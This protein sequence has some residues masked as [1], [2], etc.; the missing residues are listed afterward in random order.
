MS[1]Y[2][3]HPE[4]FTDLDEIREYIAED[5]PDAADRMIIEIFESIRALVPFPHQGYRRPSLTS[6]PLRFKLVREYVIVYAP[7]KQP[8]WV[9]AIFHGRRSPRVNGRDSQSE[10]VT[11]NTATAL[12]NITPYAAWSTVP[13]LGPCMRERSTRP[14]TRRL[15]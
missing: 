2:A 7:E 13:K 4:A 6:R 3:L 8:L 12:L 10:R 1:G 11:P 5:N 15:K 14:Q 9:V